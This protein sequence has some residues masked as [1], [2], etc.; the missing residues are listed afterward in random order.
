M[1]HPPGREGGFN[2]KMIMSLMITEFQLW[3]VMNL[4]IR[5]E[6]PEQFYRTCSFQNGRSFALAISPPE[7]GFYVQDRSA[8]CISNH[9]DCK[10]IRIYLRCLWKGRLY[11]F[12]CLP[13]GLRSSPTQEKKMVESRRKFHRNPR[14]PR[15]SHTRIPIWFLLEFH[16]VSSRI[17]PESQ[18][19]ST[20]VPLEN[21]RDLS[22]ILSGESRWNS[23]AIPAGIS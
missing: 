12:T 22:P 20:G 8:R 23:G 19:D 17:P 7:R 16:Y 15:R 21:R 5:H 14:I 6:G 3:L 4:T 11:Q 13:F 1:K 18:W 9:S 2:L 10:K